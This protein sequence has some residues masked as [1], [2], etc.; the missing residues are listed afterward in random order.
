VR[1]IRDTGRVK[2]SRRYL[3]AILIAAAFLIIILAVAQAMTLVSLWWCG[4][5]DYAIVDSAAAMREALR[6]RV[7]DLNISLETAD[8]LSGLNDR[9]SQ[10]LLGE[11]PTKRAQLDTYLWLLQGLGL[12]LVLQID[13]LA[14]AKLKDRYTPRRLKRV[15][16]AC[17]PRT[18]AYFRRLSQ[19]AAVARRHKLSPER[20]SE[21]ARNAAQ[22]RWRARKEQ[23]APHRQSAC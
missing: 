13:D 5:S 18:P 20:R 4:V 7:V 9:Y 23:L 12:K 6:R 16:T 8:A 17:V 15:L 3:D 11:P 1:Q 14:T 21:L 22:A 19:M 2:L 10:K